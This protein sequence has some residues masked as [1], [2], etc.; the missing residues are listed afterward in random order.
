M[1]ISARIPIKYSQ[2]TTGRNPALQ[3]SLACLQHPLTMAFMLL[4]LANA[5]ILQPYHP[6]WVTGK[7][8]DLAWLVFSPFLL[9]ACLAWIFPR[10]LG[11][12]ETL[13]LTVSLAVLAAWFVLFKTAAPLNSIAGMLFFDLTGLPLKLSLDPTDLLALPG[14][15]PA[16][17]I[18]QRVGEP[19]AAA[20]GQVSTQPP[21]TRSA[22]IRTLLF[23]GLGIL[24]I[25]ADMP[26]PLE[27]GVTCL[28]P[29][30]SSL[31]AFKTQLFG[32]DRRTIW[33]A[34]SSSDGGLSWKF[35]T[36]KTFSTPTPEETTT[37]EIFKTCSSKTAVYELADANNASI[38]YM[39]VPGKAVYRSEDGGE[40]L[41]REIDL[42]N[43][44]VADA[45]FD[46]ASG[47]LVLALG[48]DG[49]LVRTKDRTWQPIA[50]NDLK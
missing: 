39:F 9:A 36:M 10:R 14:L 31:I 28:V 32:K 37:D 3:K 38:R 11:Q 49:L 17:I 1:N 29:Q 30:D 40:T 13:T 45:V 27:L 35:L 42:E 34:Y 20:A 22:P 8:G 44:A 26:G 33:T 25:A 2:T 15:L 41:H 21:L 16:W 43:K 24:A 47:N 23:L 5:L 7:L 19:P 6:S 12:H 48:K 46:P 18:W 50:E 4:L